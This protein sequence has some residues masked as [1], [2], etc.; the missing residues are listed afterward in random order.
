MAHDSKT[1]IFAALAGNLAIAVTKFAAAWWTGSSAM[2][3]E[4]VHSLVD[5]GNQLLMLY[6]LR[7]S[8][9]PATP[10]HPFGHGLELYFWTFVVAILI[11]GL[12]AGVSILQGVDKIRHP[13]DVDAPWI[14]FAVLGASALFEGATWLI[15]L[16]AFRRQS[17]HDDVLEAVQLSKDPTIFTVL[18][19]DS[20]A[21]SGLAIA[22]AGLAGAQLWGLPW[23]DGV[24]SVLIGLLLAGTAT[25][26]ARECK[27]L[28]MG[29]AADPA[30]RAGLR[31]IAAANT[32]V[33]GVN[34][35][36]T[37]HFG[38]ADVLAVLSLDFENALTAGDVEAA[39]GS[40]ERQIKREF[41]VVRRIFVEAQSREGHLQ[42]QL[43]VAPR[44][45]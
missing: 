43:E 8:A 36:L 45:E 28:M 23:L 7:R 37:M 4:A 35:V 9:R 42:A 20:A 25:F 14:N 33:V 13:H 24:A 29:E 2:L 15:A 1:T 40:I 41:P 22:A 17:K 6:G 16:R 31:R 44:E 3:S 12:G 38:P 26:L 27:G 11:F 30:T 5:T 10:E 34:E 32:G 39:V 19:E 18:I 21:L